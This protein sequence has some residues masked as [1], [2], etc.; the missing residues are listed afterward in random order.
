MPTIRR[1]PLPRS[2]TSVP[3]AAPLEIT[4][5]SSLELYVSTDVTDTTLVVKLIDVYPNGYEALMLDQ[6]FMARYW[7]GFDK[8]SPL[9]TGKV[10]KLTINL[11]DTALVYN[12]GHRIGLHITGSESPRYEVHPNSFTPVMS[13]DNAPVAHISIHVGAAEASRLILPVIAPGASKDYNPA[14]RQN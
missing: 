3:L 14:R 6:G 10:Y 9:D 12:R 11:W 7:R 2:A 5:K 13:Y 1:I 4:G 8:P